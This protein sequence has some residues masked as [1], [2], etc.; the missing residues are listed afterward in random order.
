MLFAENV[1]EQVSGKE[2]L[3]TKK[4]YPKIIGFKKKWKELKF[5]A[6]ANTFFGVLNETAHVFYLMEGDAA[7]IY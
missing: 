1:E 7:M 5:L 3:V 4:M 2:S 6:S